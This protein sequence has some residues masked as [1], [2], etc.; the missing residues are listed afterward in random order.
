MT[1]VSLKRNFVLNLL[2]TVTGLLF[3]LITFPYASRILLPS[4]IGQVQF[5]QSIIDYIALC[6]SL[7]I[8][9]YAVREI[10]KIRNDK[11]LTSKISAEILLL[12]AMLT[13]GGYLI[14]L[15]LISSVGKI[16]VDIP[17]FMLLS[18]TLIFNAIGVP[19]FYQAVEDFKYITIR[20][21][22]IRI[23]SLFALFI[24]VKTKEDLLY[25]GA[26][27]VF[28]NVGSN[29]FNFIRLRKFID[30]SCFDLKSLNPG[31]HLKPALQIFV[32]NLIVSIYI[33]LDSVMLGFLKNEQAVGYYS[34]ST[35]LTKTILGIVTSF[36]TVLLP[37]FSN[38]IGNGQINEF[39][40]LANK[41]V[42][43]VIALSLPLSIGLGFMA[44]P[45][46][47]LFCGPNFDPSILTLQLIAPI[48]LFIGLSGIVGMQIL[49]PQGKE[50]MVIIATAAGAIINFT[51]N[52][53]LI[54]QYA[55]YGAAIATTCAEFLVIAIMLIIGKR[56]L[57]FRLLT[58]QNREYV[59]ASLFMTLF[60]AVI[61]TFDL[62]DYQKILLGIPVSCII[63]FFYLYWRK[64]IFV[65]QLKEIINNK[66]QKKL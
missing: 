41:A 35:R 11:T 12:H 59:V 44:T 28:A 61:L 45:I 19:W 9:L 66:I 56:H 36:G 26:I 58:K 39:N 60:L 47:H 5:F 16:Q 18:A 17:L 40:V 29:V 25:Y 65:M 10:S 38:M 13:F 54:P 50:R 63:Y 22:A 64:D 1:E 4:G 2:N 49:Y 53:L 34:A 51:L 37:R 43:F 21:V 23:I 52:Y 32:L 15:I 24:L 7:G 57:P 3:P 20:T 62:T 42:S 33:N 48:I 14:V 46:I 30:F 8:P 27:T 6:T 55:Q 31:R